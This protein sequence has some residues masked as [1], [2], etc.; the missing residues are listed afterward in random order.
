[1]VNDSQR[2][3]VAD[4]LAT[5]EWGGDRRSD[6]AANLQVDRAGAASLLNVS[7]RS[8]ASAHEVRE[9]GVPVLVAA[10]LA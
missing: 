6:Q 4:S 3:M 7:E 1:M 9:K 10:R 2:S 5:L 8:V